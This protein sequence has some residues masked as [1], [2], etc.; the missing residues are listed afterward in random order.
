[1]AEEK[2]ARPNRRRVVLASNNRGKFAEVAAIVSNADLELVS[3]REFE[4]PEAEEHGITFVENALIKAR[5]ASHITGLPAIADDSG[6]EV[7]ALGGAPGVGSARYAGAGAGDT[8]NLEKLLRE[9]AGSRTSGRRARF[10]CVMVYL[11]HAADPTPLIASGVWEG[12]IL[13]RPVGANGFGYDPI[14]Y[15]PSHRC[16]SAELSA[17]VKNTISHRGRAL[18][19]L[20]RQLQEVRNGGSA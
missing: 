20:L 13:E 19:A 6:L 12:S 7:D 9:L 5:H 8:E 16:S 2:S 3:Q 15:V 14:F 10:H 18:R 11:R 17:D 1:M 4:V